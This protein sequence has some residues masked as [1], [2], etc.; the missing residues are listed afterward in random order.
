MPYIKEIFKHVKYNVKWHIHVRSIKEA[1]SI[2]ETE[3]LTLLD[4]DYILW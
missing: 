3:D 2:E 4:A 1:E